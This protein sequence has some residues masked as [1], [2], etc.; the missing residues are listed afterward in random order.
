MYIKMF[1]FKFQNIKIRSKSKTAVA[2]IFS[3]RGMPAPQAVGPYV[4]L[5]LISFSLFFKKSTLS[6]TLGIYW[7]DFHRFFTIR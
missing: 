4:L 5:A 7:T 6:K 2:A 1:I 3:P